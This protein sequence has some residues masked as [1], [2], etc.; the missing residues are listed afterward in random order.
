MQGQ[1]GV[2]KRQVVAVKGGILMFS[3]FKL[4]DIDGYQAE[5]W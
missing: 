2:E 1:F 5:K 4:V 3:P